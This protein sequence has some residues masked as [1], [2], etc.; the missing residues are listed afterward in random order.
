[1]SLAAVWHDVECG[2]YTADLTVWDRTGGA[3]STAPCWSSGAAPAASPCTWRGAAARCGRSTP[4]RPLLDALAARAVA[5]AAGRTRRMRRRSRSRAR[6]GLRSDHR[7]HAAPADARRT[8]PAPRGLGAGGCPPGARRGGSRRR[9]SS[10]AAAAAGRPRR[11]ASR[12]PRA[13]RLGLLEPPGRR[14]H[15]RGRRGDPP[16]AAVGLPR[17]LAER[18]GAH[19]PSRRPGRRCDSRPRRA[20]VG[21]P[22]GG[23]APDRGR[24]TDYLGSTVVILEARMMELRRRRAL[25]GADE[26]L[27]RPGQHPV[28]EA[29][30]RVAR[31]RVLVRRRGA[32][33]VAR[34]G[35]ARPDLRRRG[36]GPRPADRR[37]GH[38][39]DQALGARRG[40]RG[41]RGRARGLRRLPAPRPQL[42][43][44]RRA[45]RRASASPTWRRCASP[46]RG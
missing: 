23:P 45:D 11:R 31:D 42:P 7:P 27:R 26:H 20:T 3:R 30:L 33:P 19:G 43:A 24:R 12:R 9:S 32:R 25:P 34:S 28:P 22:P 36:P 14:G 16:A 38:A 1:M 6:P 37:R 44:G 15:E 39:G 21:P 4:I 41:R 46:A 8:G 35:A 17:R 40:R 5:R 13:R 2:G 18:G 29:T 10:P